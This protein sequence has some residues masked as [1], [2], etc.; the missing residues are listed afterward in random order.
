MKSAAC[1]PYDER[2]LREAAGEKIYARGQNY[3]DLGQ[4]MLLS[5]SPAGV[6]AVAFGTSDYTVWL[7]RPGPEVSGHC[8]CPAFEDVGLCKH[9]VGAGLLANGAVE[10]GDG[11][12]DSVGKVAEQIA[13][14]DRR[15]IEKL[16]LDMMSSE[17]RVLRSLHFALGLDWE[18]DPE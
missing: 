13:R 18:G 11:P 9:M 5:T 7:K 12:T 6:L 15:Q 14:L 8:T 2:R 4:V 17:W 3:V 10:A 1:V 16:L